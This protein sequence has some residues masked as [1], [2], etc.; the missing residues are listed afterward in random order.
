MPLLKQG[1]YDMWKLRIEQYFQVQ[2][3]ALWDVIENGNSFKPAAQTTTNAEGT[4]TTLIPG[5]Y[6]DAKTLFAAIQTRFGGNE[7]TKKTQKTLL[8]QI[9]LPSEWN[10]HVVVWRNKPD[11]DTMSFDDLYNNFKIVEQEVKGTASSSSSSSSQNMAFVSSSSS[12][13]EVN[14]AYGV[15]TANT[16]VSLASTQVRTSSTQVSTANLSDDTVYAFLASQLNGSQLV[17]E[18]LEQ[19]HEDNIEEMDL[20]WQLA[21]L[22]MGTRRGPRNQDNKNMNQDSSRRTVNV[23][24]TSSTKAMI[25]QSDELELVSDVDKFEKKTAFPTKIEFVKQQ[26]KPDRKPVKYAKMYRSQDQLQLPSKGKADIWGANY[27]RGHPQ[28][29]DQGYVD[30]GCSRHMTRYMSYLSDF[31]EFNGDMLP[32]GRAKGGRFTGKELLKLVEVVNTA[33]YVQ[34]MILYQPITRTPYELCAGPKWLFDIDVLTKSMNYMPVV[35]GTNSNV[36]AGTKESIDASHSS[37]ETRSFQDCIL[38]PLWKD[39]SLFDSSSKNASKDEPKTSNDTGKKNDD[40]EI[41][42]QERP[43]KSAQDVNT[44]RPSIN[45]ASTNDNTGSLNINTGIPTVNTTPLEDTHAD[46][47]GDETEVDMSNIST[48]Y[49]V[50]F[51]PN[52][53]IHKDHSLAQVIGDIQSSVQTRRMINEQGFI[54]RTYE[55]NLRFKRSK[56][57]R[58]YARRAFAIQITTSLDIGGFTLWQRGPLEQNGCTKTRKMRGIVIRNKT[59]LVAQGYTQKEGI[60]YDKVF[61]PVARIEAIRLFLAYAS[62]KEFVV[63]QM[64]VKSAILYGKIEEEVYVCQPLGFEDPEFPDKVYKFQMSSMGELTFFLGLQVTQ[65]DD[66]IFISQDK[67]VEEI[68]KKFGFSTVKTTST[69]METSKPL[70]KDAKDEDVDVHLYKSMIGSLMYLTASRPDIIFAVCACAR[71]QVTLKVHISFTGASDYADASVDRKSTNMRP[72]PLVID[73]TVIKEWEDK[74]KAATDCLS[75]LEAA[76]LNKSKRKQ[77]KDSGLTEPIIDEAHPTREVPVMEKAK[78]AQAKRSCYLRRKSQAIRKRRMRGGGGRRGGKKGGGRTSKQ[79]RKNCYL[80]IEMSK[81]NFGG[82]RLKRMNDDNLYPTIQ[83]PTTTIDELTLAQTLIEIKEAKPKVVTSA[84]TTTTT[85][86]PKARGVAKDKGKE[87]MVEPKRPL[88]KKDQVALDEEMARNLEAQMQAKLIKEERLARQ[89]E[90]EANIALIESWDNT[91]AMMEAN[92][93]LAQRLQAEEQRETTIE[94]R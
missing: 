60:D 28:I 93:E 87:I 5:P 65:K 45:T 92:F 6:K 35:T 3:Y 66:G 69:P 15:S 32:L 9:S 50:S 71:F 62:F 53:R 76:R 51:T 74:K 20:K 17:Y 8:K 61:A 58:S 18:D 68:L 33:C 77:R 78:T 59:R 34:N 79:G 11:L 70:L 82:L 16:Q 91:Q 40:S 83:C 44:V 73:E 31:K 57:D 86:R 37:K 80:D 88:K 12:T 29:E 19:I 54:R 55:G 26:E 2:D 90:E 47:F 22:S 94:E 89:K 41:D 63:Y 1:E 36:S 72:I 10:T 39:G 25:S 14:T 24:E 85:T 21:L 48:T 81:E 67:Y 27:T 43:E 64:D 13:N 46:F 75:S 52:I 30:S 49:P 42:N 38:M 7:A 56:L 84:A 23:E 4:S